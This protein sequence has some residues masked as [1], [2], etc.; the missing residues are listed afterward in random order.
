MRCEKNLN[1]FCFSKGVTVFY[2]L[3]TSVHTVSTNAN[4]EPAIHNGDEYIRSDMMPACSVYVCVRVVYAFFVQRVAVVLCIYGPLSNIPHAHTRTTCLS[5][6]LVLHVFVVVH[7]L[8]RTRFYSIL[9]L[10]FW[11][12]SRD[13][14]RMCRS[15]CSDCIWSTDVVIGNAESG[16]NVFIP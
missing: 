3:F 13:S 7:F 6:S 15:L 9:L 16:R 2:A 8:V 1:F 11:C 4:D 14:V 5:V 10:C 12:K